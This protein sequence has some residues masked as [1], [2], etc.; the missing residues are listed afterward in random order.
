MLESS[1][2]I[3]VV[4]ITQ[5]FGGVEIYIRQIVKYIDYSRFKL[6]LIA[7]NNEELKLFCKEFDVD[8]YIVELERG[9]NLKKDYLAYQRVK[10]LLKSLNPDITHIHSSKAGV[11]GRLAASKL[12]LKHVFTPHGISYLSFSGLKRAVFLAIE[13]YFGKYTDKVL[14]CAYSEK[15]KYE[16]EVGVKPEYVK[17]IPNAITIP[18]EP[19]ISTRVFSVS[20]R[21]I[22]IG[23][24]SRLTYQKNPLLFVRICKK[25]SELYP[26]VSFEFSIL[27]AG[28]TDHLK[29]DVIDLIR[30]NNLENSF[31]ILGW[32]DKDKSREYLKSLDIFI[33]PSIFEG[34]PLSL[35]EAMSLGAISITSKCDG[36]NDVIHHGENG[37]SCM[38][39]DEYTNTISKVIEDDLLQVRI[40]ENAFKY[41]EVNHN[42][43]KFI[44]ELES[45]YISIYNEK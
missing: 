30:K 29:D 35:L 15:L 26:N 10:K 41:V 40:R 17:A 28:I 7:P 22:K 36:C 32:G 21:V 2:K 42:I 18:D 37:F 4:F 16:F 12:K 34:L 9:I 19:P 39:L 20:S 43:K 6:S 27:G 38:T 11:I 31:Q 5:S 33:L 8:Y 23:T 25:I 14:A 1:K 24:I 45:Y 44:R 13:S 3:N